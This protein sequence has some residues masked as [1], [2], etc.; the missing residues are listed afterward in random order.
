M[1][2]DQKATI[3]LL[4]RTVKGLRATITMLTERCYPS[5]VILIGDT[6]HYVSEAVDGHIKSQQATI[7]K[8]RDFIDRVA[9]DDSQDNYWMHDAIEALE[10]K[11]RAYADPEYIQSLKEINHE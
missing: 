5:K 8:L 2:E 3:E 10:E 1:S 6:G 11:G 9:S 4:H 7:T